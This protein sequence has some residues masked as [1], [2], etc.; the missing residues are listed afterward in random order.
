MRKRDPS[1]QK[2]AITENPIA[3][4]AVKTGICLTIEKKYGI[5]LDPISKS[6]V[7]PL[8]IEEAQK[9]IDEV[10]NREPNLPQV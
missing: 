5:I 10:D 8:T 2:N 9:I 1:Q 7:K 3:A 6:W 4:F